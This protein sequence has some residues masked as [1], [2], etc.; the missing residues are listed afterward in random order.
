MSSVPPRFRMLYAYACAAR[1]MAAY[2]LFHLRYRRRNAE[3]RAAALASL[4][5][6]QG[7]RIHTALLRLQG[8]FIKIGQTVSVLATVLP[9][10]IRG[11][12]ESLQDRVPA[13][14]W[15]ETQATLAAALG[16]RVAEHVDEISQDALA[17]ASIG[18][19][20]RAR[21]KDGRQV[22]IKIRH[23]GI[24]EV[25]RRDL[26]A[27]RRI[28]RAVSLVFRLRSAETVYRQ[29][30]SLIERELS[31]A[32]EA[33]ALTR[34]GQELEAVD[35][36]FAPACIPELCADDVLVLA[37]VEGAKVSD[38]E[39]LKRYGVDPEQIARRLLEAY[40]HMLFVT[41]SYHADPHPGNMLVT[42]DGSLALLDFGAVGV[43]SSE[44]REGMSQF[45]HAALKRDPDAILSAMAKMGF[46]PRDREASELAQRIVR[47][48]Y[49]RL[50]E[51]IDPRSLRLEDLRLKP[52]LALN[53]LGELLREEVSVRQL[54]NAF[55]VP[56]D[57]VVLER[58]LVILAHVCA[59][60]APQLNP[61]EVVRPY[62]EAH[63]F[64]PDADMRALLLSTLRT[65]ALNAVDAP[66]A[67]LRFMAEL[68]AGTIPLQL[69]SA[70]DAA[71][72]QYGQRQQTLA[73]LGCASACAAGYAGYRFEIQVLLGAASLLGLLSLRK[74]VQ[75]HGRVKRALQSLEDQ[76]RHLRALQAR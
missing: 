50:S 51:H 24:C 75:A 27:L 49:D 56:S 60:L 14:R 13:R 36:V 74:V 1:V 19:V 48:F 35:G 44:L 6:Q 32:A 71:L 64:D 41:G 5:A 4:H 52:E 18:Q 33:E 26:K 63:I 58:T 28:L 72:L 16:E 9:D 47:R 67:L 21:L 3:L 38:L 17:S 66:E 70:P 46:I 57:W 73:V 7:Q 61:V 43:V 54:V 30:A 55:E 42:P 31:F 15:E 29:V 40:G 76:A 25:A 53:G 37:Y 20:H 59:M 65:K 68:R 39:A 10:A 22:V 12:L 23:S 34:I 2:L 8:L 45:V 62:L 69:A 11:P